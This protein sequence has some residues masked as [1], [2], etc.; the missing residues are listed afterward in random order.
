MYRY[1]LSIAIALAAVK[2]IASPTATIDSANNLYTAGQYEKAIELYQQ[3]TTNGYE[4]AELYYNLGN[5][6]FKTNQFPMAILNYERAKVLTPGD[7]DIEFNLNL[8]NTHVIDKIDVMPVF[9]IKSWRNNILALL[10]SNQWALISLI[11]FALSLSLFLV[12]VL[13]Q[14]PLWRKTAFL[15]GIVLFL[16]AFITFNHARKS[17]YMA[18]KEPYAIIMTPSVV[19]RSAPA[20]SGTDLFVIHE[21]LKVQVTDHLGEWKQIVLTNG[22]K[23]WVKTTDLVEI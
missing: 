6:Y 16:G 23:G 21:G 2:A 11:S 12:F 5:A 10:P 4:A 9:F 22:S 13:S 17:K 18:V 14:N 1:I 19:V 15:L 8:A 20:D 7:A 3:V